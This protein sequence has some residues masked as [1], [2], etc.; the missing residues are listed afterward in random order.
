VLSTD[1]SRHNQ[2]VYS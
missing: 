1:S 2:A